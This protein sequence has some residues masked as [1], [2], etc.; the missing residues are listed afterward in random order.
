[1]L[2]ASLSAATVYL[3]TEVH[4]SP[5]AVSEAVTTRSAGKRA[6]TC[7]VH[8]IMTDSACAQS[9]TAA[10]AFHAS[11]APYLAAP[12]NHKAASRGK[13]SNFLEAVLVLSL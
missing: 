5:V 2:E 10:S 8:K 11:L 1:V 4:L 9:T 3:K 7:G 13:I 6:P 12:T